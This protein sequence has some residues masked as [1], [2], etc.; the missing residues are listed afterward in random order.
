MRRQTVAM[1]SRPVDGAAEVAGQAAVGVLGIA[2]GAAAAAGGGGGRGEVDRGGGAA[3]A[4]AG[5]T[6]G[7]DESKG[8]RGI[9]KAP[10]R[11]CRLPW[12]VRAAAG[13]QARRNPA[14]VWINSE[15]SYHS[16]LCTRR[17]GWLLFLPGD[18]PSQLVRNG[19]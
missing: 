2:R 3:E 10:G 8:E 16:A 15:Y 18:G 5:A 19:S 9:E 4:A 17:F 13:G 14:L 7:V 11:T 1:L 12:M 6:A